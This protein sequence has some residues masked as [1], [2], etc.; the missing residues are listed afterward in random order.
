[1]RRI[2]VTGKNG[3]VGWELQRTLMTLGEVIAVDRTQMDLADADSIRNCI[4]EVK[5]NLI[6]NAA[7]YTAVDKVESEVDLAM[8][9]NG[10]APGIMAEEAKRLGAA[11]VHYSTDYVFDGT[12]T[13]PYTEDDTP[14]PLSIYGKS[15][16]AGEEAI[17]AVGCPHLT[18]RTSWVYGARGKNFL[19]TILKL[20]KERPELRVVNDQVGAPTW[21]RHIAEATA[22]VLARLYSVAIYDVVRIADA[23]GI[24]HLTAS[25]ETTW[26]A[27]AD[28]ILR[29][30]SSINSESL[31]KLVPVPSEQYPTAARRPKNSVLSNDKI[32]NLLALVQPDW[33]TCLKTCLADLPNE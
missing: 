18:L 33:I 1:M 23:S 10:L 11:I 21:C 20:S 8:A 27:F 26:F 28:V 14:R 30:G 13:G 12:K 32:V 4:R 15:K 7:A 3:Q 22:H 29:C 17:K 2:L 19:R 6:V 31:P 25:G 9:I 24:Y 5:P 16:L